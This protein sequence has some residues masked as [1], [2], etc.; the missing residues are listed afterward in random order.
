MP[1]TKEC[2]IIGHALQ[3]QNGSDLRNSKPVLARQTQSAEAQ[4]R[5][6]PGLSCKARHHHHTA[7]PARLSTSLD[8]Q[9]EIENKS[10]AIW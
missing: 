7:W 2:N 4:L 9:T 6:L 8:W 5:L 10:K 3:A 1:N